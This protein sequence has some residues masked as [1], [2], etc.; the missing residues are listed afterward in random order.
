MGAVSIPVPAGLVL[1]ITESQTT[2]GI[3]TTDYTASQVR[4]IDINGI[5]PL[6]PSGAAVSGTP[7]VD[8]TDPDDVSVYS[9]GSTIDFTG[10][11]SDLENG[12]LSSSIVWASSID[13]SLGTG[14]SVSATLTD[15][16]HTITATA[17]D[18]D[19]N[20]GSDSIQVIVGSL[21]QLGVAI[22]T[23]KSTYKNRNNVYMVA[24]VEDAVGNAVE[25]A[26]VSMVVTTA[27]GGT[28]SC[29]PTTN[30]TG[31]ATCR[32]R[33][34]AKRDGR[35]PNS[36][37]ATADKSGYVSGSGIGSFIVE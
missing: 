14:A 9:S 22:S 25:G 35:G 6:Y 3:L 32:Y 1:L 26:V 20:E 16:T 29:A 13:G 4:V 28:L 36:I 33:V 15:G 19:L 11:A 10:T 17:T 34:N 24:H 27:D 2:R 18:A 37:V 21:P 7:E 31:D 23:D 8:I 30:I 12:D 5:S